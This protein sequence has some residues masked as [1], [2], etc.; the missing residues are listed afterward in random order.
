MAKIKPEMN[1]YCPKCRK[2][3]KHKVKLAKKG[4]ARSMARG[5]RKHLR[6]LVGYGGKVAGEK[7]VRKMGKRQKITLQCSVCKK[8]HERVIGSRTKVKL[9]VKA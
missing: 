7:S 5:T 9:E 2:H 6:K 4:S 8:K 3:T 1:T